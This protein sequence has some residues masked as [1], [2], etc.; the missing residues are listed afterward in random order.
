MLFVKKKALIFDLDGT[1]ADTIGAIAEA[2]NMALER[3][4]Y[5]RK[6]EEQVRHA[7]GNGARMIVKRLMPPEEAENENKVSRVLECYDQMYAITHLHTTEMYDGIKEMI[8]SL[9]DAGFKIAVFSNK[10]D[11]YVK[12]LVE[13]FFPDGEVAIA[14]GQT[15]IPI[16]PDPAGLNII[17][18]EMGVSAS[19]CIFVGDSGVDI[20]TAEN[21]NMDFIGVGWGFCGK[22]KLLELGADTVV[23][24]PSEILQ[25]LKI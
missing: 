5:P 21:S 2:V 15:D 1:L 25:M 10:Q 22:E 18:G 8:K 9:S 7:V 12:G 23:E 14:R 4:S 20:K 17:L 16:K 11:A 3:F 24:K 19:E 13:Q 6:S